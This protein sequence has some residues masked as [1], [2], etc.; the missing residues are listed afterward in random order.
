MTFKPNETRGTS[1]QVPR[2]QPNAKESSIGISEPCD[3]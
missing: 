2:T 3:F 1:K